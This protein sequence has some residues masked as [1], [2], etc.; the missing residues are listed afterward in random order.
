MGIIIAPF[1][2]GAI[3]IVVFAMTNTVKLFRSEMIGWNEV[4]IGV[5]IAVV[6]LGAIAISY[7][8]QGKIWGLSPYFRIPIGTIFIPFAL[9]LVF[10]SIGVPSLTYGSTL[11]LVSIAVSGILGVVFNYFLF[12]LLAYFNVEKFY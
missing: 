2:I 9:Y 7:I 5:L 12:D 3:A 4:G 8:M 11:L 6:L 10:K 1:L